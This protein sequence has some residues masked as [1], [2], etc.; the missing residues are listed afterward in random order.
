MTGSE[1][2]VSEANA[3]TL[4]LSGVR[5]YQSSQSQPWTQ[6]LYQAEFTLLQ[7]FYKKT[8]PVG[9]KPA[10]SAGLTGAKCVQNP[11]ALGQ[12][13]FYWDWTQIPMVAS[14]TITTFNPSAANANWRDVTASAD[15]TVSV[16][17]PTAKG[18]T[19]VEIATG[20]TVTTL[21]DQLCIHAT[22]D[23]VFN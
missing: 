21:A 16:D 4:R 18:L 5:L 8:F 17:P 15:V 12:P 3:N 14:P 22:A 2:F 10:Q 19:G 9:T 7:A 1:A 13:S 11:I 20:A 6:R 23:A